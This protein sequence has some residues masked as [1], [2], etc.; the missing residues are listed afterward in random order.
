MEMD[1]LGVQQRVINI[2]SGELGCPVTATD[3][4]FKLGGDSIMVL[5]IMY[6]MKEVFGLEFAPTLLFE[7]PIASE[8]SELIA[9]IV[10]PSLP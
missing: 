7:H 1:L 4:F 5:R 2:W 3:D 9:E 6:Q 8:F 10:L